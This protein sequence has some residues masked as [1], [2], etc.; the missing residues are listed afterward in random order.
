MT[1][2]SAIPK[3]GDC[4]PDIDLPSLAG[5]RIRL[6]SATGQPTLLVFMRHLA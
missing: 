3:V 2:I 4:A 6:P 1:R 5:T